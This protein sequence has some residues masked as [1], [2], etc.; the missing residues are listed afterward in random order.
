MIVKMSRLRL[1][2][3]KSDYDG[4]IDILTKSKQF[5]YRSAHD[6]QPLSEEEVEKVKVE[7]AKIGFAIEYLSK[8]NDE[9]AE[10]VKRNKGSLPYQPFKKEGVRKIINFDRFDTVEQKRDELLAAVEALKNLS[11]KQV[12]LKTLA[13]E[14]KDRRKE[15]LPFVGLP[16][17]FGDVVDTI[18]TTSA[19]Y[20]TNKKNVTVDIPE[21]AHYELYHVSGGFVAGVT[22]FKHDF[23]EVN[24]AITKC[25]FSRVTIKERGCIDELI[26]ICDQEL[27]NIKEQAYN[28]MLQGLDYEK[29]LIDLMIYYDLLGI[30]LQQKTALQCSL[31]TTYTFILDGWVPEETGERIVKEI[32]GRYEVCSS[33]TPAKVEDEPPTLVVNN[34]LVQPFEN[35]TAMYTVPAYAEKDPNP[36]M[37]IW[38]FVLFGV[39]CGDVVYGLVLSIACGLLLRF[40]KFEAGTA[41]L[42]KMFAIC[43]VSSALWGVAFDSYLGYSIGF[44]WFIPMERPMLLLG[45]AL[46]L[47]ILQIAYGYILGIFR[48]IREKNPMGAIFDMGMMLLVVIAI[49]LLTANIFTGIFTQGVF[50]MSGKFLP[51]NI[52]K[53]LSSAGMIVLLVAIVG[54][55]LT[56][57]RASKSIVGKL[58]NGLYG[59][60]GLVNLIS[61]ILS[62]CRLFGLGLAGGAIAYAFNA[63]MGSIFFGGG[64]IAG[65]II[66]A[67]LSLF[68]HIFN[69]AISLLGAYVHNARLQMLEFYGKFL[70]GEGRD[71]S[72]VGSNTKYVR[73]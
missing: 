11:F 33:L 37:A 20:F 29:Y 28:V 23:D 46:V 22:C 34:K 52:V 40:K 69:L 24:A 32:E 73:Y 3:L 14:W 55:F 6:C 51:D 45:L 57:G 1:A 12:E 64:S 43:G 36:H 10:I 71:F 39:M 41:N 21:A 9:A 47:G 62:Y 48:C 66:G 44:G 49:V 53:T 7:Q 58:G 13:S 4:V 50:D 2:G 8:L 30:R 65:F 35:I 72:Y 54:I 18:Q 63:L 26:A 25:G 38:Y 5:E 19:L 67:V 31:T 42:I 27:K 15:Y 17:A 70:I 16:F 60:Y 61:D 59:V 56:A 68:L